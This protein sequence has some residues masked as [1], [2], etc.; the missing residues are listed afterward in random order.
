MEIDMDVIIQELEEAAEAE[1]TE[2]GEYW[3]GLCYMW[4]VAHYGCTLEFA[5]ALE[6]EIRRTY[7]WFKNNWEWVDCNESECNKCGRGG[8]K[9]REL[10]FNG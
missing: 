1:G 8:Y 6:Q 5:T 7:D 9:Y 10:V 4:R 3:Q 2:C